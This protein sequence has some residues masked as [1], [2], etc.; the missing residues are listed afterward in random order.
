MWK[1][2]SFFTRFLIS[3]MGSFVNVAAGITEY[4]LVTFSLFVALGELFWT[5]MYLGLKRNVI[6]RLHKYEILQ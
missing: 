6:H 4:R 5:C 2:Y 3:A 1:K